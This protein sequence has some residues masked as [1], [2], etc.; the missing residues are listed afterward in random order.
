MSFLTFIWRHGRGWILL[1]QLSELL[2]LHICR[3][4]AILALSLFLK[5][6]LKRIILGELMSGWNIHFP[7]DARL[8]HW[9]LRRKHTSARELTGWLGLIIDATR[10][11][12]PFSY[13]RWYLRWWIFSMSLIMRV[14]L[15]AFIIIYSDQSITEPCLVRKSAAIILFRRLLSNFTIWEIRILIV[16]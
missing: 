15:L 6:K 8:G 4:C 14:G 16:E 11:D 5:I 3:M 9:H 7:I 1:K 2:G 12:K 13:R 10:R